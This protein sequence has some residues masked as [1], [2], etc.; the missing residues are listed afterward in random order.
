[1][2]TFTAVAILWLR[3]SH[4]PLA[5]GGRSGHAGVCGVG[6]LLLQLHFS[7]KKGHIL[8]HPPQGCIFIQPAPTARRLLLLGPELTH[9]FCPVCAAQHACLGS[10]TL[11]LLEQSSNAAG[12]VLGLTPASHVPAPACAHSSLDWW[13][14]G[15]S[16][17]DDWDRPPSG[18][19]LPPSKASDFLGGGGPSFVFSVDA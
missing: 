2:E 13:A 9:V 5:S 19:A 3:A 16:L 1:M 18:Q 6:R 12:S 8:S 4:T 10:W 14:G 17:V 15:L 11:A 7:G